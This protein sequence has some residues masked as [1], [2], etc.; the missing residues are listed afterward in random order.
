[1]ISAA[2]PGLDVAII[3]GGIS[4]I[5]AAIGLLKYPNIHVT[6]YEASEQFS[7]IGAGLLL[8]PNAKRALNLISPKAHEAYT[9]LQTGN[10]HPGHKN[11]WY[12]FR[13]STGPHAGERITKIQSETGQSSIHR[14]KFLDSL[15]RLVPKEIAQLGKALESIE[16][17]DDD[18]TL[19]FKDG[20]T[21]KA[22][23][24]IG[25]DGVHSQTR[26]C[27]F[28]DSWQK[29]EPFFSGVV[30][31]RAL[32]PMDEARQV[33]GDEV[34]MNSFTHCGKDT[35]AA[36]F[37]ID[38][39]QTFNIIATTTANKHWEGP[40]VQKTSDFSEIQEAFKEW[41]PKTL[42]LIKVCSHSSTAFWT[43]PGF[44]RDMLLLIMMLILL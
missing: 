36:S 44:L 30:G 10:M 23:C 43:S 3:G 32:L 39:G 29:Y 40:W 22:H 15:V 19:Y 20:T 24:V 41:S 14:A 27:I 9:Q 37:P 35:V 21:A 12:E 4:G 2:K 31:F 34:A 16:E 1:M 28:K 25:A 7:E 11:T 26:R 38:F 42:P 5:C 6:I 18:V 13:Y 17:S 33:I 8:G